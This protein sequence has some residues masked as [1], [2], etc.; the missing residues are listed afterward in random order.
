MGRE[1]KQKNNQKQF[2]EQI[3]DY[4]PDDLEANE[5][6]QGFKIINGEKKK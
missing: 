2:K 1:D 6:L 5:D 4:N 3:I